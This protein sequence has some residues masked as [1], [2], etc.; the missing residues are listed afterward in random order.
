MPIL[1]FKGPGDD[2]LNFS[3]RYQ[4]RGIMINIWDIVI[5]VVKGSTSYS[6][7]AINGCCWAVWWQWWHGDLVPVQPYEGANLGSG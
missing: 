7:S 4:S 6:T 5:Y 2:G 3:T 1:T